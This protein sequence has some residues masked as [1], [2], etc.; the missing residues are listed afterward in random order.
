MNANQIGINIWQDREDAI[1]RSILSGN[2][3]CGTLAK[4]IADGTLEGFLRG[5]IR[6]TLTICADEAWDLRQQ[7]DKALTQSETRRQVLADV[8]AN[9]G[10]TGE[11]AGR[12][13][14]AA[15]ATG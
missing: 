12:V 4:A 3:A 5:M 2:N 11:L 6:P 14:L 10:L 7:R 9:G 15:R 1:V 8:A 13:D